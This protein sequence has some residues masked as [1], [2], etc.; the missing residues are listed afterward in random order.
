[1]LHAVLNYLSGGGSKQSIT[2]R[3]SVGA[4]RRF[5]HVP[6]PPH[7][8]TKLTLAFARRSTSRLYNPMVGATASFSA[9]DLR[10]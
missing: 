10:L 2:L 5:V 7:R 3:A 8:A 9:T 6:K 4:L 1:M